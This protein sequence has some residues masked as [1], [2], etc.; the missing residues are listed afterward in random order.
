MTELGGEWEDGNM[1]W[2]WKAMGDEN[3]E[4]AGASSGGIVQV[5]L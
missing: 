1:M 2:R 4:A 3:G 5:S